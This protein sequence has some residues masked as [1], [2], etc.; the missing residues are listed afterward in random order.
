MVSKQASLA[1][2]NFG[3]VSVPVEKKDAYRFSR[4]R[5]TGARRKGLIGLY[6]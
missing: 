1:K 5:K 3:K 2:Q 4:K 6:P